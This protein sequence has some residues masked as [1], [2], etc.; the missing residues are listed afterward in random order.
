MQSTSDGLSLRWAAIIAGLG[1]LLNPVPYAEFSIMPKIVMTGHVDQTMANIS[2][3]PGM[4]VTAIVCYLIN[5]IGDIVIAWALYYLL[6]PVNR[7][8]SLLAAL[9]RLMYTAIALTG[10]FKL[11]EVYRMVTTPAYATSFGSSGLAAQVDLLLHTFRYDWAISIFIFAIH[12][13]L[14]GA[15]IVRSSYIPK[16]LGALLIVNGAVWLFNGLK[17][18]LY[19]Q[20]S[21]GFAGFAVWFELVFMLWLLIRGWK[22]PDPA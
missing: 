14:I 22:I 21:L 13:L 18:Y 3:H 10:W 6:A 17:P 12:L 2:A 20:A 4:F 5:F 8:V 19:P 9:F 15:L 1:Y 16:W 7:A 11:V